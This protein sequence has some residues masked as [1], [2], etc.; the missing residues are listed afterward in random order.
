ME[1]LPMPLDALSAAPGGLDEFRISSPREVAA[2]LRQFQDGNL[3]L[4]LNGSHG[5]MLSTTLWS[6]DSGQGQAQLL[7]RCERAGHAA[8]R[9]HA[10]N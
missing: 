2:I 3:L 10:R 4:N 5:G 8:A 1:T 6:V 7:R 9:R